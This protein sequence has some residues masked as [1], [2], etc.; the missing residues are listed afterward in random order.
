MTYNYFYTQKKKCIYE[1]ELPSVGP[2]TGL[3]ESFEL[4]LHRQRSWPWSLL[5]ALGDS[6][7]SLPG[8]C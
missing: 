5:W 7:L 1:K 4:V 2:Q 3:K 6:L 8:L